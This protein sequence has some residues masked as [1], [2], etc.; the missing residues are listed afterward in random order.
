MKKRLLTGLAAGALMAAMLPGVAT[1]DQPTGSTTFW[2]NPDTGQTVP[3]F[4]PEGGW[5]VKR[6][7]DVVPCPSAAG[8]TQFASVQPFPHPSIK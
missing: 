8:Y 4:D 3:C 5:P 2:R 6:I 7:A 1:A